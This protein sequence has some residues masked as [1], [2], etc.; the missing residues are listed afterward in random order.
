MV[1]SLFS[2]SLL[3]SSGVFKSCSFSSFSSRFP[4][5]SSLRSCS[6]SSS[7]LVSS[8]SRS[9]RRARLV[10]ISLLFW[11]CEWC[12]IRMRH[13]LLFVGFS[14]NWKMD[15]NSKN[16]TSLAGFRLAWLQAVSSVCDKIGGI[17]DR[18]STHE[19]KDQPGPCLC[20][21]ALAFFGPLP[22]M[23]S[24]SSSVSMHCLLD[25]AWRMLKTSIMCFCI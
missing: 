6:F 25:R 19:W 13:V 23:D 3:S 5:S 9:V 2:T 7:F 14:F 10:V 8:S 24:V 15:N 21:S 16:T 20:L 1:A 4:L 22:C 18:Y 17:C 12:E 11:F